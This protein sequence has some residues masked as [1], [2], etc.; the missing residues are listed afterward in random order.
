MKS[1]TVKIAY[2]GGGSRYWARDLLGELALSTQLTGQVDLYDL[3]LA[4]ARKNADIAKAIFSRPEARTQF[5]VRAVTSLRHA[6]QGADFVVLSIEPGPTSARFADLIIPERFGVVQPVGDTTGP[7]GIARALRAIPLYVN[8]GRQIA[9]Y[10]PRAWVIN[11]TNPMT[12]CLEALKAGWPHI[13]AMGC[14]HEVFHTQ[15]RLAQIAITHFEV[16]A[17][18]RQEIQLGL[19][20]INH[21]TWAMS[22]QWQG[23]PLFPLL[24]ASIDSPHY[25]R[26]RAK[27]TADLEKKG[28]YFKG[29]GLVAADLFRRF[30]ALGAAG[31]RHLVEFVPWYATD[32]ANLHRWGVPITPYSW[33]LARSRLT[34]PSVRTYQE[35]ALRSSD[36]E[37]VRLIEALSGGP[38]LRT[39]LNLT[40]QGQAPDL[41]QGHTVE[42]FARVSEDQCVPEKAPLLPPAAAVLVR[43]VIGV[44]QLTLQAGLAQDLELAFHAV[45][46]DPL[47]NLPVSA[48]ESMFAQMIAHLQSH[49]AS[50]KRPRFMMASS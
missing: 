35:R 49:V 7:G 26:S 47:V 22:A 16:P 9:R 28:R 21:F 23:Q 5:K 27:R 6:L 24:Q 46:A 15:K 30:G 44:Q 42:T 17:I 19:S 18:P 50:W 8:F 29:A 14:C 20:G 4:A 45:L 10:C 12:L 34:D 38:S 48:T 41:P 2:I 1:T 37:G 32:A 13:K 39:H 25:F 3:D 40:N 31:D 36:E 33:R 43:R 11:Y